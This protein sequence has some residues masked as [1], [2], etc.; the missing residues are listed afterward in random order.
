MGY[1]LGR[2]NVFTDGSNLLNEDYR[3]I[4]SVPMPGRWLTTGVAVE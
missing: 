2:V 1:A 3:E 4:A